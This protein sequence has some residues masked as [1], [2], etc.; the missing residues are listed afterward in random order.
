MATVNGKTIVIYQGETL[1]LSFSVVDSAGVALSLAGGSAVFS[2][3][4]SGG[5]VVNVTG[6]ITT[7]TVAV[8]FAHA[9]TQ[10]MSGDYTYQ[11]MCKNT[12]GKIVMV[13]EGAIYVS[14]SLNPDA[15]SA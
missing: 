3:R 5:T 9:T 10:L 15:V 7:S 12:G 4:K 1:D 13:R 8:T 11:L 14:I 2:Y 6:S